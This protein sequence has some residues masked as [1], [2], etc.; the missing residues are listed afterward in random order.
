MISDHGYK[1]ETMTYSNRNLNNL[2]EFHGGDIGLQR[3]DEELHFA[4]GVGWRRG[5]FFWR[6]NW[7]FELLEP[8]QY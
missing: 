8:L 6:E 4:V 2:N 3:N 5:L 1:T 7:L